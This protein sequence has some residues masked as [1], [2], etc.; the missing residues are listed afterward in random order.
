MPEILDINIPNKGDKTS[1]YRLELLVGG[2]KMLSLYHCRT[3]DR[4]NKWGVVRKVKTYGFCFECGT[5]KLNYASIH[6]GDFTKPDFRWLDTRK[7]EYEEDN[8]PGEC[9]LQGVKYAERVFN[10]LKD[11]KENA[12]S[13]KEKDRFDLF[14]SPLEK[15]LKPR[16]V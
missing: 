14:L 1:P 13:Y 16:N 12:S 8:I 15:I 4:M 5:G 3:E 10:F 2:V 6:A 9:Y 11:K 7:K